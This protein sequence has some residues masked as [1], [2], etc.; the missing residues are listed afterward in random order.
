MAARLL[1]GVVAALGV[2]AVGASLCAATNACPPARM[3]VSREWR[4]WSGTVWTSVARAEAAGLD[5]DIA[6]AEARVLARKHLTG[7]DGLNGFRPGEL[8]GAMDESGCDEGGYHY[9]VVKVSER[10]IR[11]A[12]TLRRQMSDSLSRTP[13]PQPAR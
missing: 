13:T 9:A 10:S 7:H 3:G 12:G 5:D 8:R 1:A 4:P 11:Q 6:H 2:L